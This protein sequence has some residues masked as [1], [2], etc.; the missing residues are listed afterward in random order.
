METKQELAF[1][2]IKKTS[3]AGR[4]VEELTTLLKPLPPFRARQIYRWL[5]RG[6]R[7]FGAMTDLSLTLREA[8]EKR[9]SLYSSRVTE[10]LYGEDGTLKI[11]MT[12]SDG[13]KVEAVL[14]TDAEGRRTACLSTQ[15]GCAMGCVFCRTGSIGFARNLTA[16]EI[17]EQYLHVR[18]A[19]EE[20]EVGDI[21]NGAESSHAVSMRASDTRAIS[22]LVIM[23]MGE[24]LLNIDALRDALNFIIGRDAAAPG[25]AV[26]SGRRITISTCGIAAGI[27]DLADKGP[28]VR[29]A[30]SLTTADESLR[31]KLM[32]ITKSNPLPEVKEAL[33]YYQRKHP[34][35]ITLEAVLLGGVNT[36]AKDADMLAHFAKGLDAV[37]NVIPWNPVPGACADGVP[38]C[39]PERAE[40]EEF[41]AALQRR[42]LHV[43]QRYE[44][45]RGVAGACGQLGSVSS[46]TDTSF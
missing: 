40:V 41:V 14:L 31:E 16:G 33:L 34:K 2:D 43:T 46:L 15:A 10:K 17:V 24:P 5:E 23:G 22:N 7:S 9:F 4:S 36:R 3:L 19:E 45:G 27:R 37:V 28:D 32:P 12:L 42:R 1:F 25:S 11:Q 20:A 6:A 29:L 26:V 39:E 18:A 30:V 38:L 13:N 35:R 21:G 8:L 44:K